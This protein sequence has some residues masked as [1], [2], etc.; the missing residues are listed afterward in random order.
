MTSIRL[1]IQSTLNQVEENIYALTSV[2]RFYRDEFVR[3]MSALGYH[4][5][6]EAVDQVS[7]FSIALGKTIGEM[8]QL[9]EQTRVLGTLAESKEEFVSHSLPVNQLAS[10]LRPKLMRPVALTAQVQKLM[11]IGSNNRITKLTEATS[12]DASTMR[13]FAFITLALLPA[14]VVAVRS[15]LS[16]TFP[17]HH[18]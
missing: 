3:D 17:R 16:G 18:V 2:D 5:E 13:I 4:W 12:E 1:Q 9:L 8:G 15:R 14:T 6:R 7:R 11:E 10:A